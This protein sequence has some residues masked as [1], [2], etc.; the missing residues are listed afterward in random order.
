MIISCPRVF[1]SLLGWV[2]LDFSIGIL[3]RN[4][5]C[6][7]HVFYSIGPSTFLMAN[8]VI[9]Q[10]VGDYNFCPVFNENWN[11][12]LVQRYALKL[13][14]FSN[15]QS[16]HCQNKKPTKILCVFSKL[17]AQFLCMHTQNQT[18][19]RT[20]ERM[21]RRNYCKLYVRLKRVA[22]NLPIWKLLAILLL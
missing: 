1:F 7:F 13:G 2:S 5:Y 17:Q 3:R 6:C 14:R 22:S 15:P 12:D 18:N 10:L 11:V 9:R 8:F 4:A 21:N 16:F 20:I 19:E